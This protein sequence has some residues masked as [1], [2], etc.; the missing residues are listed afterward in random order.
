MNA[1]TNGNHYFFKLENRRSD[2]LLCD[3]GS[4]QQGGQGDNDS[5]WVQHIVA[6]TRD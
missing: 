5:S 4:G 3:S 6:Y 1:I 2:M